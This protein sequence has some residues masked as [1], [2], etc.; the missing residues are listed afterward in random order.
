MTITTPSVR[1]HA[2]L[3]KNSSSFTGPWA[4][5]TRKSSRMRPSWQY[6]GIRPIKAIHK[7]SIPQSWMFPA[8]D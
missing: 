1:L 4:R 7:N 2:L 5:A 8:K 6:S 3:T